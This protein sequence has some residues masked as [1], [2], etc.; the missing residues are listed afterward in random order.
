MM[1]A[2]GE[3]EEDAKAD[4]DSVAGGLGK[5][6]RVPEEGFI[7]SAHTGGGVDVVLGGRGIIACRHDA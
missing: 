5:H 7:A 6:V 4:H 2:G 1:S 3:G